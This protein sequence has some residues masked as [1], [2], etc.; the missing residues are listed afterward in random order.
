MMAWV[1]PILQKKIK[2]RI[3]MP[4]SGYHK[5][6]KLG[7]AIF[8]LLE[9][10]DGNVISKKR[11]NE[12]V[13]EMQLQKSIVKHMRN[14]NVI[15]D[16]FPAFYY[17]GCIG[18]EQ[19]AECTKLLDYTKPVQTVNLGKSEPQVVAPEDP[20]PETEPEPEPGPSP[21]E[22]A[23]DVLDY[24]LEQVP[25]AKCA[26]DDRGETVNNIAEILDYY[27]PQDLRAGVDEYASYIRALMDK[28]GSHVKALYPLDATHFFNLT[29]TPF[30]DFIPM[31]S[32]HQ[33]CPPTIAP[34]KRV[35]HWANMPEATKP[36]EASPS[37]E[38]NA[39]KVVK[40]LPSG[41]I[42]LNQSKIMLMDT[43]LEL[44]RELG[45]FDG[46]GSRWVDGAI[47]VDW[48]S[49]EINEITLSYGVKTKVL[50]KG[51]FAYIINIDKLIAIN[52]SQAM[53]KYH[54][55][56]SFG[57]RKF[58]TTEFKERGGIG[59]QKA[60]N[61]LWTMSIEG[62]VEP[63]HRGGTQRDQSIYR[64]VDKYVGALDYVPV[65]EECEKLRS[66]NDKESA[67]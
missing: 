45:Y 48:A 60:R 49:H 23:E 56:N 66:A 27:G 1:T 19:A 18:P 59:T 55:A 10:I 26:D 39:P 4:K 40:C 34:T 21:M 17:K 64:V 58:T 50:T 2:E 44:N 41:D 61:M 29:T 11:L 7:D 46:A 22:V 35:A 51:D 38:T 42:S 14:K 25:G 24:Y 37:T 33:G 20:S 36:V 30:D 54:I 13:E 52:S 28:H 62:Y 53:N 65:T 63:L 8:A 12:L 16:V 57:G 5:T 6:G 47:P 31:V 3:K 9:A 32:G 15:T 43:L 67:K